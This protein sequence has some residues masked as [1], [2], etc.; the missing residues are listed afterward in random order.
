MCLQ[1]TKNIIFGTSFCY[2]FFQNAIECGKKRSTTTTVKIMS[3]RSW[4]ELRLCRY[5]FSLREAVAQFTASQ[6]TTSKNWREFR[7]CQRL[8]LVHRPHSTQ[9]SKNQSKKIGDNS[10]HADDCFSQC[11]GRT[12]HSRATGLL[13][14]ICHLSAYPFAY[15][16]SST[17]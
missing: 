4:R 13:L 7:P 17:V 8:F 15:F 10:V 14:C 5:P 12:V 2:V 6:E 11:I 9:Q 16:L 1:T 3:G